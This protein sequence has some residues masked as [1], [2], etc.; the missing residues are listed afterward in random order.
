MISQLGPINCNCLNSY[1]NYHHAKG[2]LFFCPKNLSVHHKKASIHHK[3][4]SVQHQKHQFNTLTLFMCWT[5]GFI[6]WTDAFL[7]WTDD[8]LYW[9]DAFDLMI[10]R[11]FGAEKDLSWCW[12]DQLFNWGF[13]H[14]NLHKN[15]N[16]MTFVNIK[17]DSFSQKHFLYSRDQ[18][19]FFQN[20]LFLNSYLLYYQ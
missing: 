7:S 6:C 4:P 10:W 17:F 5:E 19:G 15:Q 16:L 8:F 11:I 3:K 14:K 20:Y 9:T 1:H 18:S 13:L 12:T 2:P